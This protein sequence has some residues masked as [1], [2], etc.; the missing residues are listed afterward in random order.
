MFSLEEEIFW[1]LYAP[2]KDFTMFLFLDLIR[3]KLMSVFV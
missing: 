1:N 3:E 2:G